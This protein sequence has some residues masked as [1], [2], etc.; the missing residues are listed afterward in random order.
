MSTPIATQAIDQ[1]GLASIRQVA[2]QSLLSATSANRPSTLDNTSSIVQ[3]SELGQVLGAGATLQTSL[4]ALQTNATNA[5]PGTVQTAAQAFVTAFNNVQ[6][7]LAAALPDN[8]QVTQFAQTLDA[9][10]TATSMTGKPGPSDLRAI[11]I[12]FISAASSGSNETT[13][14]LRID[15][16]VLNA[17]AEANP[18]STA[19]RLS[20]TTES[21]LQQVT[22]FEEQA[23]NSTGTPILGAGVQLDASVI[24]TTHLAATPPETVIVTA[25]RTA[26]ADVTPAAVDTQARTEITTSE[27]PAAPETTNPSLPQLPAVRTVDTLSATQ[28]AADATHA[29]QVSMADS[30]LRDVIFN[31]AYSALIASSHPTDFAVPI[32]RT[33]TGAIPAEIPGA[34]LPINPIGAISGDQG[35][36][37]AFVGR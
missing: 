31:P 16:S 26:V 20:D 24:D 15:Q 1:Y 21:L 10:A 27:T 36:T 22:R 5:T 4:E 28:A 11:G 6:Q 8:A 12:S 7:S 35:A 34:V 25:N 14:R 30:A 9:L 33:R 13:A 19:T 3:V 23:A 17:A 32:M 29:L 37:S 2:L 18:A